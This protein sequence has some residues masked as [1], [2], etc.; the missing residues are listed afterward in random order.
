MPAVVFMTTR[1]QDNFRIRILE[2]GY[3]TTGLITTWKRQL[4]NENLQTSVWLHQFDRI[5]RLQAISYYTNCQYSNGKCHGYSVLM[6]EM[7]TRG[8]IIT[9]CNSQYHTRCPSQPTDGVLAALPSRGTTSRRIQ[10]VR[11]R[12]NLS[13]PIREQDF[14]MFICM[15]VALAFVP[16]NDVADNYETLL[17]AHA[18]AIVHNL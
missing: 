14:N 2:T 5:I 18:P 1:R 8:C 6:D 7:K 11:R 4:A 15:L 3:I 13:P 16:V 10:R 17:E 9:G 12:L